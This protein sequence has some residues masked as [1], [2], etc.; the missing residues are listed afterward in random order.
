MKQKNGN[1]YL[2]RASSPS[3]T[4]REVWLRVYM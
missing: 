1:A 3:H 2:P 4:G